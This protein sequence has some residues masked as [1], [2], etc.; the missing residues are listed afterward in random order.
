MNHNIKIARIGRFGF[1]GR[2]YVVIRFNDQT[3]LTV[4]EGEEVILL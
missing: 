3:E 1:F 2:K 4:M